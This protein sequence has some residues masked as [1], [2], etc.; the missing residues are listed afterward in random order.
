MV[1]KYANTVYTQ[2]TRN[3]H[4]PRITITVGATLLPMPREAAIVQS[5]NALTA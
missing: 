1:L 4:D 2:S 5:I 3:T